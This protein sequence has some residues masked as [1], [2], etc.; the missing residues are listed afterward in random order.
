MT[1]N[2]NQQRLAVYNEW[3]QIEEIVLGD[4]GSVYI[5]GP[6]P[7][8][9]EAQHSWLRRASRQAFYRLLEGRKVPESL[10]R[11]YQRE[12]LGL[13]AIFQEREIKVHRAEP[14]IPKENEPVGLGQMF[15]RDPIMTVGDKFIVGRLQ[16][17]MRRKEVRGLQ[18]VIKTLRDRGENVA[19]LEAKGVY[20][21]GGD[22]MLDWPRVYVGVGKY[23]SNAAGADWL[24]AVLGDE[25]Q[26]IQVSLAISGI[27]HLDCCMSL[28]GPGL[29][30]IHRDA[31]ISPLPKPLN[32]Y[33]FIEIDEQTRREM[34]GNVL[35][36]DPKTVIVQKRHS[37]LAE[38]LS[39]KGFDVISLDFSHHASLDGAFRCATAPLRRIKGGSE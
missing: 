3:D 16:I 20:L 39:K 15:A 29:G 30:I 24:Q 36:L 22:V 2:I 11:R 26:V 7:I 27:L 10:T 12:Q 19:V 28:I 13:L 32:D 1:N 14:I 18:T 23:A 35:L 37:A 5:P 21:E 25:A 6:H 38:A 8:E 34:G 17:D 9:D 33:E 31:L 4:G